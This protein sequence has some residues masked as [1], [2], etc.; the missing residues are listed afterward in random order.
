LYPFVDT[1]NVAVRR[2]V[3]LRIGTFDPRFP[4]AEDIDFSWRLFREPDLKLRYN[5]NAIVF[6]R[7]RSTA[8]GFFRQHL[9]YGRGLAAL[10]AKYPARLPWTWRDELRGWYTVAA[11]GWR[12]AAAA[13]RHGM[14]G[15]SNV[16]ALDLYYGFLRKLAVRQ[17]F[18]W[19]VLRR[20]R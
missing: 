7:A 5:P 4:A 11:I 3:F 8:R 9:R 12:A 19:G 18:L 2:E 16:D 15:G 13:L 20:G 1:A 14:R 6:H 17:G 10:Q